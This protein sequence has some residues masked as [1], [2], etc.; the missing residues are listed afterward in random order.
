[1]T[2][3]NI[4]NPILLVV[5]N[6]FM[7]SLTCISMCLLLYLMQSFNLRKHEGLCIIKMSGGTKI[8]FSEADPSFSAFVEPHNNISDL[9]YP[10]GTL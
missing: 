7:L 3:K 1:M 5:S 9:I 4:W 8:H 6:A 2:P 10:Y